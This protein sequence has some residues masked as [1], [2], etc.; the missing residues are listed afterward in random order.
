MKEQLIDHI[1]QWEAEHGEA[2]NVF[3]KNAHTTKRPRQDL[4]IPLGGFMSEWARV[5]GED[6]FHVFAD[7][8]GGTIPKT[9][10][11]GGGTCTA[12]LGGTESPFADHLRDGQITIIDLRALRPRYFDWDF[13]SEDLRRWI[14]AADAYMAIPD[15]EPAEPLTP[16]PRGN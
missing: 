15:V 14:V 1:R 4:Y 7:C 6:T 16:V 12:S 9:G 13:L 10:Q 3:H 11:G 2:P 8:H 5:R